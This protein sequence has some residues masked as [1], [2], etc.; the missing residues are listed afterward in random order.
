MKE[1]NFGKGTRGSLFDRVEHYFPKGELSIKKVSSYVTEY[2]GILNWMRHKINEVIEDCNALEAEV[3]R[4]R[5]ENETLK[6]Q[7]ENDLK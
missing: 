3:E 4:L 5:E 7:M 2:T 1:L 6:K